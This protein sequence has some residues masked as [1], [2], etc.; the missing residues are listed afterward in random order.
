MQG[1]ILFEVNNVYAATIL[2]PNGDIVSRKKSVIADNTITFV[3]DKEFTDQVDEIGIYKIQFHLYDDN[4]NRI[5][6]P[7]IEFEVKELLGVINEEDIVHDYGI[8][9]DTLT[10]Y[11]SI[12]LLT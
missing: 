10:K 3:I 12:S 7:P 8:T 2:K 9:D 6:I 4:D 11:W 1:Q 5:T